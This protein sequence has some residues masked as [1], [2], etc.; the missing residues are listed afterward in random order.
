MNQINHCIHNGYI[1]WIEIP[2]SFPFEGDTNYCDKN[3]KWMQNLK[4]EMSQ[5]ENNFWKL[6]FHSMN[7]WLYNSVHTKQEN[8]SLDVL[9]H[10]LR[11][12][13]L[14]G[15]TFFLFFIKT[16]NIIQFFY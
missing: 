4:F 5:I 6:H 13:L 14:L 11:L 9:V 10:C 16:W 3:V 7:I 15:E 1:Y 2:W 12:H 8:P